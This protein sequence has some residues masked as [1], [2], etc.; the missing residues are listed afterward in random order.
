MN[1]VLLEKTKQRIL[2]TPKRLNMKYWGTTTKFARRDGGKLFDQLEEPAC[3]TQACVAGEILLAAK[4]VKIDRKNGGIIGLDGTEGCCLDMRQMAT[5]AIGV[6]YIK[7]R[8]LFQFKSW[9]A[10]FSDGWPTLFETMYHEAKTPQ[11]R[12]EVTAKRIDHFIATN[13]AE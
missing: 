11:E 6:N 10:G 2:R 4:L 13:G 5:D 12:A 1:V 3:H 7:A 9:G 8:K